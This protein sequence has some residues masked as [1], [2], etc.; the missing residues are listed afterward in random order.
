MYLNLMTELSFNVILLRICNSIDKTATKHDGDID[1]IHESVVRHNV[2]QKTRM[3]KGF[4]FSIYIY[5]TI[6]VINPHSFRIRNFARATIW[7]WTP[8]LQL[9]HRKWFPTG[10]EG[11]SMMA[12]TYSALSVPI[13]T[14]MLELTTT[15]NVGTNV[16][17]MISLCIMEQCLTYANN[18]IKTVSIYENYSIITIPSNAFVGATHLEVRNPFKILCGSIE[19]KW[20]HFCSN[21]FYDITYKIARNGHDHFIIKAE[22]PITRQTC[23]YR[24]CG[25]E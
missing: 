25:T 4:S 16:G 17:F 24:H 10:L 20:W 6:I 18:N 7:I 12:S 1:L 2:I 5:T 22:I 23:I 3:K 13:D 9:V 11:S 19:K 14:T 21:L 15:S 8:I